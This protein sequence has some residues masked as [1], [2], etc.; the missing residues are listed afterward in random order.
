MAD[1]DLQPF[2][3]GVKYWLADGSEHVITA[4]G[5]VLPSDALLEK[6]EKEPT[7]D[8]LIQQFTLDIQI[9]LDD[10][11]RTRNYDN[12]LS[13]CTYAVSAI[14]KFAT[15]AQYMIERRDAN[16]SIGYEILSAVQS[17]SRSI[18]SK[19]ELFNELGPLEWPN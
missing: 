12:C 15:E 19:A 9:R 6:P 4:I 5:E 2:F 1:I 3:V 10:F 8:E 16:W 13:C 18:P 17:G 7:Q 11:A 14:S